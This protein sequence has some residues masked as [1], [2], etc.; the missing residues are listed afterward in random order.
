[1]L[2]YFKITLDVSCWFRRLKDI[3]IDF[4][5]RLCTKVNVI[6]VVAKVDTLT[7]EELSTFK[8]AVRIV[9]YIMCKIS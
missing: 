7:P 3:D 4:M 1:M 6:P 8:K 5:Q 9:A 2:I